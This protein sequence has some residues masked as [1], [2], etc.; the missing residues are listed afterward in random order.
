MRTDSADGAAENSTRRWR[1]RRLRHTAAPWRAMCRGQAAARRRCAAPPQASGSGRGQD[2][3]FSCGAWTAPRD[4]AGGRSPNHSAEPW[5]PETASLAAHRTP[6][7]PRRASLHCGRAPPYRNCGSRSA[8]PLPVQTVPTHRSHDTCRN[9]SSE[10]GHR[11]KA[12][13]HS[14]ISRSFLAMFVPFQ[15]NIFLRNCKY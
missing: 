9:R 5:T 6:R 15:D 12:Q 13:H 2:S 7:P 11:W 4:T 8:T 3:R 14:Q 1:A 10:C